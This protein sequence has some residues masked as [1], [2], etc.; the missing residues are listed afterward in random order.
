MS[1]KMTAFERATLAFAR[2]TK[3]ILLR[4]PQGLSSAENRALREGVAA[5][6]AALGVEADAPLL[7]PQLAIAKRAAMH[8]D[9]EL[10]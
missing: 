5:I 4:A 7:Q 2:A 10:V 9:R 3:A 6:E 8:A 1:S